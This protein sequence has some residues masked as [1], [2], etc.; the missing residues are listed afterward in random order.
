MGDKVVF[1]AFSNS[2]VVKEGRHL[3]ACAHCRNMT[4]T[5]VYARDVNFPMLTCAACGGHSGRM[6]WAPDEAPPPETAA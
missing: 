6:G 1:L 2:K 4:F 3:L 5:L